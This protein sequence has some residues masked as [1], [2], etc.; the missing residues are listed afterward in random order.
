M[1]LAGDIGAQQTLLALYGH[2]KDTKGKVC[3]TGE[4]FRN[5]FLHKD[6]SDLKSIFEAFFAHE[7]VK[8]AKEKIYTVCLSIAGPIEGK[9]F[10]LHGAPWVEK[11]FCKETLTD[12]LF[13]PVPILFLNDMEAIGYSIFT[14]PKEE[15]ATLDLIS[16]KE[17]E[18]VENV[19]HPRNALMLVVEGL[20]Q[21]LWSWDEKRKGYSPFSSEGGHTDFAARNEEETNLRKYLLEKSQDPKH[22]PVSYEQVLSAGG[23]LKIFAFLEDHEKQALP[24]GL[25]RN[26]EKQPIDKQIE[27]LA[28]AAVNEDAVCKK[29]WS[30]FLSILGAQAGNIA[31]HYQ[32]EEGI[33][34]TGFVLVKLVEQLRKKKIA[35]DTF[36]TPL[37]QAF[38]HK[39]GDFSDF[40][41]KIPIHIVCKSG[42]AMAGAAQ[43]SLPFITKGFFE[44]NKKLPK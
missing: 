28:E 5:F 31:L 29:G 22:S 12:F 37:L 36:F 6:Y 24:D 33:Y 38:S 15:Q 25:K 32:A 2:D 39:E 43:Y 20:G 3:L 34:L 18:S 1:I 21:A 9:C 11:R 19:E 35:V 42:L 4:E 41:A 17:K 8:Q 14:L 23:L 10:N 7:T 13:C 30:M 26:L 27:I 16:L 44:V 40:N